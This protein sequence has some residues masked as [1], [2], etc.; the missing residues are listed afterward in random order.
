MK[1]MFRS[2]VVFFICFRSPCEWKPKSISFQKIKLSY[3]ERNVSRLILSYIVW[4]IA[5][6]A[7]LWWIHMRLGILLSKVINF[8]PFIK[9]TNYLW[10]LRLLDIRNFSSWIS[11]RKT[12]IN[13]IPWYSF[14]QLAFYTS[15]TKAHHNQPLNK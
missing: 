14:S 7:V 6:H 1:C 2:V 10:N 11:P 15:T 13:K 9:T 12:F 3:K 4:Y 5:W 8:I